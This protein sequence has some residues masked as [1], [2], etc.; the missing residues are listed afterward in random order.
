MFDSLIGRSFIRRAAVSIKR[1]S[2]I[3]FEH[4]DSGVLTHNRFYINDFHP[5]GVQVLLIMDR[6]TFARWNGDVL[7]NS[8]HESSS[9]DELVLL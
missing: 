3:C 7:Q 6:S 4:E 9:L 2:T 1:R 5:F 8:F